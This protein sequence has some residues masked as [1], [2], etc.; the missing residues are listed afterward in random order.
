MKS[1]V[2]VVKGEDIHLMVDRALDEV[3]VDPPDRKVVIK[4]YL[5]NAEP[6]P[7]NT[8]SDVVEAIIDGFRNRFKRGLI[9]ATCSSEIDIAK[10][11]RAHNYLT[12]ARKYGLLLID[13]KRDV[14]VKKENE[15]ALRLKRAYLPRTLEN[16]YIVS[17]TSVKETAGGIVLTLTNLVN[18]LTDEPW[19]Y[20]G[21]YINEYAVDVASYLKPRLSVIDLR[22]LVIGDEELRLN[23]VLMSKDPVAA[24]YVAA[25]LAGFP[26]QKLGYL[27]LAEELGLGTY[28]RERIEI[29]KLEV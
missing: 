11:Y 23:S 16:S 20:Q 4:P 15:R 27:R 1:L 21:P 13:L 3:K 5:S 12:L 2:V 10:A 6:Y 24:D 7:E 26:V 17:V 25:N 14:K 18:V 9:I 22:T 8:P 28:R 29:V 19:V